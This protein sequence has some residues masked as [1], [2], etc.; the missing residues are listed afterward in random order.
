MDSTVQPRSG[1]TARRGA[2]DALAAVS[3]V[4]AQEPDV[5]A[6]GQRI[7]E[8]VRGLFE[9]RS[10][11]LFR[12]DPATQ[13]LV[14]V[15]GAG[16]IPA[17]FA[18][19]VFPR[20][21]GLVGLA[22]QAHH[23]FVSADLLA[24]PRIALPAAARP[25]IAEAGL[26]AALAVPLIA[27]DAVIGALALADREGRVFGE[28]DIVLGQAFAA[29]AAVALENSRLY[30]ESRRR[31]REAEEL[32]RVAGMLTESLDVGEVARRVVESVRPLFGVRSA[33]VRLLQPDGA[34]RIVA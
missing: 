28:E 6:V 11:V 29:L 27:K 20:G 1:R 33:R 10:A 26:H 16:A 22:V 34:L 9:S 21:T 7:V 25:W 2:A 15:A 4:I 3:R 18:A 12:L 17:E 31:G 8:A 19:Q 5:T 32:A 13:D 14:G 23:P 30:A 24:D